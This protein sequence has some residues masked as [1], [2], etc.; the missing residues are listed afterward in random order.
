ME[1]ITVA[2]IGPLNFKKIDIDGNAFEQNSQKHFQAAM[3]FCPS[4]SVMVTVDAAAA[5]AAGVV[6]AAPLGCLP[7]FL[8]LLFPSF[9][10]LPLPL[11]G[12]SPP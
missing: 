7:S 9:L 10:P 11:L 3:T 4:T 12:L 8:P 6:A 5:T 1:E 2:K